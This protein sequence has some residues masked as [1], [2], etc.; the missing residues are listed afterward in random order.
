MSTTAQFVSKTTAFPIALQKNTRKAV[1]ESAFVTK[2]AIVAAARGKG[3]PV[4]PWM[5]HYRMMDIPTGPAALLKGRGGKIYMFERGAKP[6]EIGGAFGKGLTK[7]GSRRRSRS[8]P[9]LAGSLDHP[10][11]GPIEHPGFQGRPFWDAGV[12]ASTPAVAKILQS[13]VKASMYEAFGR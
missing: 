13:A 6:H 4:K 1:N 9:I 5:V 2:L 7:K 11:V 12:R 10:V 8:S 3:W